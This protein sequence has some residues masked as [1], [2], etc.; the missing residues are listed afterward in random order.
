M[1]IITIPIL[2]TN[3]TIIALLPLIRRQQM[4]VVVVVAI[5]VT[6]VRPH[7]RQQRWSIIVNYA[8]YYVSASVIVALHLTLQ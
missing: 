7:V 3:L 5:I 8:M 4:K 2:L 6:I 1:L